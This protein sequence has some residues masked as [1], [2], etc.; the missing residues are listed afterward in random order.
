MQT[1]LKR[2]SENK[3]DGKS[4][5]TS[6]QNG[7]NGWQAKR[8]DKKKEQHIDDFILFHSKM[9]LSL[10]EIWAIYIPSFRENDMLFLK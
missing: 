6:G 9:G 8:N 4:N 10:A 7:S 3:F 5:E 2:L 1:K